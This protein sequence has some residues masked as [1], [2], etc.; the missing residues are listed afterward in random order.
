MDKA[1]DFSADLGRYHPFDS[2][3]VKLQNKLHN[4]LLMNKKK[5]G[6][7]DRLLKSPWNETIKLL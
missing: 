5:A 2:P 3:S 4:F 7:S 1:F 6:Q